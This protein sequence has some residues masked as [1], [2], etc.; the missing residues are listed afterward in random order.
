MDSLD[1]VSAKRRPKN[2]TT[3][4]CLNFFFVSRDAFEDFQIRHLGDFRSN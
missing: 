1:I 2:S 4:Y 3:E